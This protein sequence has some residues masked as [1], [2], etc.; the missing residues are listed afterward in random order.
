MNANGASLYAIEAASL[1][2]GRFP[3]FRDFSSPE[4]FEKTAFF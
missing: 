1:L 2:S 3:C 4:F